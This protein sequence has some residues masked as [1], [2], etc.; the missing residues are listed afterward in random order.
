MYHKIHYIDLLRMHGY[1][2]VHIIII[3]LVSNK[4]P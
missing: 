4:Q 2:L 3:Y 1:L